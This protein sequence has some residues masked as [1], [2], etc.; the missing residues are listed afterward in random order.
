MGRTEPCQKRSGRNAGLEPSDQSD[1]CRDD[2]RGRRG[3]RH[4]Q[5]YFEVAAPAI[6]PIDTVGAGDTFCG[7]FAAELDR[8]GTLR[9]AAEIAVVAASMACLQAGAQP[10]IP[11]RDDVLSAVSQRLS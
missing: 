8:G 1:T 10:S 11:L 6:R 3:R 4:P 7:Y 9:E 5:D 2:G